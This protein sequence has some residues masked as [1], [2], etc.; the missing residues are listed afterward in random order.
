MLAGVGVILASAGGVLEGRELI[1]TLDL[2]AGKLVER[3][4]REHVKDELLKLD[5]VG[6]LR[7]HSL[8]ALEVGGGDLLAGDV[9]GEL[10]SPLRDGVEEAEG[11]VVVDDVGSAESQNVGLLRVGLLSGGLVNLGVLDNVGLAVLG[12]N[13]A[14]GLGGIALADDLGSNVDVERSGE[15]DEDGV[16]DL[17]KAVVDAV[18]VDMLDS[19]LAHVIKN[20]RDDESLVD[21]TVSVGGDGDLAL[22]LEEDLAIVGDA[23]KNTLLKDLDVVFAQAKEVV[24]AEELLG[25]TTGRTAGHDV[26]GHNGSITASLLGG[27]LLNLGNSLALDLEKRLVGRQAN[28]VAALGSRAAKSGTLTTSHEDDGNLTL[29]DEVKTRVVP[30]VNVIGIGVEDTSGGGFGEGLEDIG[31]IAGLGRVQRTV[32]DL[33]D[34]GGIE[35]GELLVEGSSLGGRQRV[36]EGEDLLLA[37]LSVLLL[38]LV[39]SLGSRLRRGIS[40]LAN[41]K[42]L[43][44]GLHCD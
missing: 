21:T 1:L 35:A 31:L 2:E 17:D 7:L 25:G 33:V 41:V 26:P 28:I 29:G 14:D 37:G 44:D 22:G 40:A 4:Q 11:V 16:G 32:G 38:E 43:L 10:V 6:L 20:T 5:A 39:E 13:Q 9:V 15:A 12:E 42:S 8:T 18:G 27:K 23:R 3:Q 19:T 24:L 30:L 34:V 36:V